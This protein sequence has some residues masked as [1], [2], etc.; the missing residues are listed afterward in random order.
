[1][2]D[3]LNP[4]VSVI[5]PTKN[6]GAVLEGCLRCLARQICE[7]TKIEAIV[8]DDGSTDKTPEL[9]A[10]VAPTLPFPLRFFR[11]PQ[12]L[13]ANAARNR[14]VREARGETIIFLDDDAFVPEGWLRALISGF[15]ASGL[16]VATGPVR[17]KTEGKL[18]GR[19]REETVTY[20]T[21]VLSPPRGPNGILVPLLCNMIGFRCDF[22]RT[23]FDQAVQMPNEETDWLLRA[24]LAVA[25]LPDAWIWHYKKKEELQR[26][27]LLRTAWRRGGETGRWSRERLGLSSARRMER[28][29]QALLT[30]LRAYGHGLL[31]LCWGGFVV[32][33]AQTSQGLALLGLSRRKG[34]P[35]EAV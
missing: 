19:H 32:G 24:K 1:M 16:P 35:K 17:L 27:R 11:H 2:G 21:E 4:M 29:R 6:R 25:F 7:D 18:P 12:S 13:G 8:V 28:A 9:I 31:R 15:H 33:A 20:L 10:L 34:F 14:G 30:A 23:P 5:I 22:Q 3:A 26:L